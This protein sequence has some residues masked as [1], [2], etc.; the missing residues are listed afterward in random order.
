MI[1]A[2]P[3]RCGAFVI[4]WKNF[5][6]VFSKQDK[7]ERFLSGRMLV[8]S[9]KNIFRYSFKKCETVQ[10]KYKC[11]QLESS[12]FWKRIPPLGSNSVILLLPC[13]HFYFLPLFAVAAYGYTSVFLARINNTDL[14]EAKFPYE[15]GFP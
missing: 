4:E 11:P 1:V 5:F 9:L 7:A 3:V 6:V 14:L 2:R 8:G 15:L 13:L 10:M 12:Q